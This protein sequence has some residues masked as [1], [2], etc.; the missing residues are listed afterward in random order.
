M[1]RIYGIL[2]FSF[3][4]L[5]HCLSF[6]FYSLDRV[7]KMTYETGEEQWDVKIN[8]L[9]CYLKQGFQQEQYYYFFKNFFVAFF[10]AL[11]NELKIN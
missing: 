9:N 10:Y 1:Y 8:R 11:S 4:L 6:S 5:V 2:A 3:C 7:K